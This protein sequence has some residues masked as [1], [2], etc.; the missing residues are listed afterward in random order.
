MKS[1]K[2]LAFAGVLLFFANT[3][4][5]A[6]VQAFNCQ[7]ASDDNVINGEV[8]F[9]YGSLSGAYSIKNRT[10]LTVAEPVVGEMQSANYTT[11]LGF[12]SRYLLTP[13]APIV[14]ASEGDLAD[15]ISVSWTVD[16]LSPAPN[17]GFKVYRN[18]SFLANIDNT[19]FDFVDFNVIAGE[20]Y[21]Y[22]IYGLNDYG[23]GF[24]G[25]ALGFVNPN[26]VVTGQV[27]TFSGNPVPGAAVMLTPTLGTALNFNGTASA[28]TEYQTNYPR[29]QFSL[30]AWV[31]IGTGNDA[32]GILDMGSSISK[33]WWIHT[34]P[35]SSGKGLTVGIGAGAGNVHELSAS[36]PAGTADAWHYIAA[37]Y[38][39]SS[40]LF[41]LDG[42]LISTAVAA[43]S[44]D[45]MP[46]FFGKKSDGTG[47]FNG[48]L[49]EVRIFDR[50][51]S[52]TE[53]QMLMD[54]TASSTTP[55]LFSYWKFDEGTGAK[56]FNI[57]KNK[58]T[59]Y[60]CGA[61]WTSDKPTVLNA[62]ST[63]ETGFYQIEGINYSTGK[64]FTARVEKDFYYNQSL[65]FNAVNTQRAELTDFDLSDSSTVEITA[66]AF[67]FAGNQCI[68][69]KEGHF[70]LNLNAGHLILEMGGTSHDFGTLGMGF[71]RLSFV[72]EQIAGGSSATVTFYK[73]GTFVGANTFS[74]VAANFAG[75]TAW[76][77]GAKRTGGV[78]G[79]YFSGL[80]DDVAFYNTLISLPDIQTAA[81]IGTD[82]KHIN[83]Q[84]YFPL[85]EGSDVDLV[86]Y[87]L[88]LTG[89]GEIFGATWSTVAGL[90]KVE[91]HLF[92]PSTRLVTLNPSNT[93]TDQVDFIDQST[94][95]VS[96]YVRFDGTTCFQKQV[97]ILVNGQHFLPAVYTDSTG[98]FVIDFEPGA[99]A[100]LTPVYKNHAYYPA[101]W[102]VKNLASPVAGILFR[103]QTQRHISGQLAGN[104][105]CRKSI[106]P[107]DA[108]GN[109][110]AIVKVKVETLDGCLYRE[111]QIMEE[112]GKFIFP[113]L[114]PLKYT[115]AVTEHSNN[116]IYNY[117][118]LQGGKTLDLELVSDTTDFIYYSPPEIEMTV[119]DTN[120]CGVSMLQQDEKYET[121]IKVYQPYDG[122]VCYLDT[123]LLHIDNL[124]EGE[125]AFDTLMTTGKLKH[126][127]TAGMPNIVPPYTK[128]LTILATANKFENTASQTAVVL[129]KRP[130]LVNFTSTS[131]QIPIMI[132]RDPPGDGSSATIEKGKTV[133]NGWSF[134][135]TGSEEEHLGLEID[136]GNKQQI[137]TGTPATGKITEVGVDNSVE[138][139][140]RVKTAQTSNSS[141]EVCM[142]A[143]E[144]ISTSSGDV[145]IGEDADVYVGGALNLLFGITDDLRW[146]TANCSF[147][148]HPGLLIFPDKFATT[149]IY[150]HYQIKN[151]V[152]PNLELVGDTG[153]ANQWRNILQRNADLKAA[154]NFEKNLSFDAGVNYENATTIE[155]TKSTSFAFDVEVSG[156]IAVELGGHIDGTGVTTK[157]GIDLSMGV[158][159]EF[160][161]TQ[162]NSQTV[163]YSLSDDDIGDVFTLDVLQDK[164][165]GTPVFKT[166]SGNS[167]C[168]YE[169]KT[170]PHDGVEITVDKTVV[171]NVPENDKAVFK[172][173]LGNSSQTNSYRTY[174]FGLYNA[175]NPN[176]AVIKVQ[177]AGQSGSF[178]I[179]PGQSQ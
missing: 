110:T 174:D 64:T 39:G 155:N 129:G 120:T 143:T 112:N 19:T 85:N 173:T 46:L 141:A 58:I 95:P 82:V 91:P 33:N 2:H 137:I 133:C 147:F 105:I 83:L 115:V 144:T 142:T 132:L 4:L 70:A 28:F 37:T 77:L 76:T 75:G 118:Q 152:I 124:I 175:S 153:S 130:R 5:W 44:A 25:A 24:G 1:I 20:N 89:K 171:S 119:L 158:S 123:A 26:G 116:V 65:E 84:N 63:D 136:L 38:N 111:I 106:I 86:D 68:L 57:S 131:P 94:V 151:V 17:L 103:N 167:S 161:T 10:S 128:T 113:K 61:V 8:F 55:G 14:R 59:A 126:K 90:A 36:F 50:Q 15:R 149:F 40:L 178:G 6:Q 73:D 179:G 134:G 170:V 81:N 98:Y 49:D 102:E 74:G 34:T 45:S 88:G 31:K 135:L 122:G 148:I 47:F 168:P 100:Q 3:Q 138:L 7:T 114:P 109:A 62:G 67:D 18:G 160:S 54:K 101:F 13:R 154:A 87:G 121:E 165:Y 12:W 29:S 23:I 92:T 72:I 177:G 108:N 127:F 71:H 9:N 97:E 66:K 35:A 22:T 80:I 21:T 41:Y 117:F 172:F 156:S 96:G 146:D 79:N 157:F 53:I 176:G 140:L 166:V 107:V 159:S 163:A 51:L 99:T 93:S 11:G 139:G 125:G 52:Q 48:K 150:S 43:I 169:P 27:K 42:E 32:A 69:S 104:A 30:S 60:L 56:A 16:P 78:L 162:T 164:V 145:I